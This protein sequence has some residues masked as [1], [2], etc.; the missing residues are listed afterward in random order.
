MAVKWLGAVASNLPA[1][2][3]SDAL[4]SLLW[5]SMKNLSAGIS[6]LLLDVRFA[7]RWC[8]IW[9]SAPPL[10]ECAL[11]GVRLQSLSEPVHMTSMGFICPR[12]GAGADI[13]GDA[14]FYKPMSIEVLSEFQR[15][16]MLS[17]DNF[18]EWAKGRK[19]IEPGGM[20]ECAEWLYGF[21]RG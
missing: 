1:G 19:P 14:V 7:L 12:C 6:P 9:G 4:L 2:C 20:K 5:G 3:E 21:L 13:P 18:S 15:A 11:C 8:G 10:E 17:K 16:A